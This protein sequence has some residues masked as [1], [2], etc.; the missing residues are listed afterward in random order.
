MEAALIHMGIAADHVALDRL[1]QE[2]VRA[3]QDTVGFPDPSD[4]AIHLLD[5]GPSL[6]DSFETGEQ[7]EATRFES[8]GWRY[9]HER[10]NS[11]TY[12]GIPVNPGLNIAEWL[13][14]PFRPRR[15]SGCDGRG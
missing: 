5:R 15:G 10:I 4:L 13:I 11:R 9:V 2:D 7:Y 8:R 12:L 14:T 3:M 1:S 6:R